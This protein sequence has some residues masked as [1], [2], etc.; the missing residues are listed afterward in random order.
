MVDT[1]GHSEKMANLFDKL[2]DTY[3]EVGVDFFKPIAA[4]LLEV[5]P[6]VEGERWLD[7]GC[8]RGAVL[9]PVAQKIGPHGLA[10]GIDISTGMIDH[11]RR[12][13]LHVGLRN[14]ECEVDDAQ[15]P[16]TVRGQFDTI[17]SSLVLFFLADPLHALH[18]WFPLLKPSGRIGVTTFGTIDPRWA[19]VDEVFQPHLPK[20]MRDVRIPDKDGPFA[21]DADLEKIFVTSGFESISTVRT[22]VPVHFANTQHWYDFTWSIGQRML[23]LAIP[24]HAR[25]EVRNE[26]E[27]RLAQYAQPDG[28]ITFNQEIRITL[29]KRP[30]ELAS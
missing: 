9:L 6:P 29:G 21:N 13:A 15:S 2:S 5:M 27:A 8:G 30:K 20:Q 12:F 1:F 25:A 24:E 11:A 28:S 7:I 19:Y 17:S 14:V 16:T 4:K 18:N 10:L 3:D 26:A 22:S 23:W